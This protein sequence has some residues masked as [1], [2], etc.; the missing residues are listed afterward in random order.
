[1][2]WSSGDLDRLQGGWT[3]RH[4]CFMK[5]NLLQVFLEVPPP[6]SNFHCVPE[7]RRSRHV[8]SIFEQ[9]TSLL[10]VCSIVVAKLSGVRIA[11][12]EA[13]FF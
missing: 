8:Q 11:A 12:Q 3:L 2:Q 1:M 5:P 6:C 10:M 9:F 7:A 4:T 13:S